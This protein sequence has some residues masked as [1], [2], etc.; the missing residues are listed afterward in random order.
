MR[1]KGNMQK[2]V[3]ASKRRI[4]EKGVKRRNQRELANCLR[5]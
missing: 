2:D 3:K 4:K 5:S 1:D